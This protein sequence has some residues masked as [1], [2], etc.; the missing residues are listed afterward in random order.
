M[1]LVAGC[2]EIRQM[3]PSITDNVPP[4]HEL[5]SVPFFPQ[6][7]YQCGPAAL[8]MVLNYTDLPIQPDDLA[9]EVYTP[10]LKG[11]LQMAMV[12]A[13]R[14]HGRLAYE[15]SGLDSIFP[16][17]SAGHP[18]IILQN[19]GLSWYPVWHYAV[20]IGYD[21]TSDQVILRSGT[22]R[23]KLMPFRIFEKTWAASEYWGIL[24]LKPDQLPARV[25]QENFLTAVIG[26]EKAQRF[27]AAIA[28]YHTALKRW[29]TSLPAHMGMGNSYYAVGD[30]GNA[31]R[32]FRETVRLHPAAGSAYN[33]LA[34]V[35][36]EQGRKHEALE[37]A[38]KA[39]SIGGPLKDAYE[40]T[41]KA[42]ETEMLH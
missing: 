23:R 28:G 1:G 5:A 35:L 40:E 27:E 38:K 15:I 36:M 37:A 16:E 33:N 26:L 25:Q 18:V 39:V 20:V 11:S 12:G 13:V 10:S 8:A 17:I 9:A 29:P 24:V 6:E 32:A 2:A 42:I 21:L 19:L 3:T 7:A 30:L 14:R 22:H 4:I 31:E 34:Q 41:L